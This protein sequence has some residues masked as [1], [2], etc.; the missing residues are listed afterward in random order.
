MWKRHFERVM[1]GEVRGGGLKRMGD[2]K[3][4]RQL[5]NLDCLMIAL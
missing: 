2:C 1:N 5:V 3:L 4:V